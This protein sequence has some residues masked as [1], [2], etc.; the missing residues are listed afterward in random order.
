MMLRIKFHDYQSH[1]FRLWQPFLLQRWLK[2]SPQQQTTSRRLVLKQLCDLL[3]LK[4]ISFVH[5]VSGYRDAET[6]Q[7]L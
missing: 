4:L 2:I 3:V 1:S 7:E 5:V 6:A